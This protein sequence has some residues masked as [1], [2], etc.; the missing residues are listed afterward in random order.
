MKT[1]PVLV[2]D[3]DGTLVDT[4]EY[5][6]HKVWE[7][8]FFGDKEKYKK[9]VDFLK[10][11]EGKK[12]NRYGIIQN[13]LNAEEID[14]EVSKYACRYKELSE[15]FVLN[16]GVFS[17]TKEVLEDLYN[18]GYSMYIVS[19]GGTDEDMKRMAKE[20]G[21]AK[22]FK[23]IFGFSSEASKGFGKVENFK[24]IMEIESRNNL[25][26]YIVIGD[27]I[28][29]YEFSKEVG[30]KF[31]GFLREYNKWEGYRDKLNLIS[32]IN[33]LDL[34]LKNELSQ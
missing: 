32:D 21:I 8:V 13:V 26:D 29:D 27:S 2:W 18:K 23:D 15:K 30:T 11:S 24:K 34:K 1:K 6:Y 14:K 9:A 25:Q 16:K 10:T 4:I 17:G 3:W 28:S 12:M 22:Y 5:K 31:I 19:G 33:F 7:G 20:V